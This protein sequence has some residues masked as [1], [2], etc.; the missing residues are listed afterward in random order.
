MIVNKSLTKQN[1]EMHYFIF[2]LNHGCGSYIINMSTV[3]IVV[4]RAE[5][6]AES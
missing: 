1:T 5:L 2:I 3:F 6:F 4:L